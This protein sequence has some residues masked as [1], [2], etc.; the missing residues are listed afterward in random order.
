MKIKMSL[1]YT[2]IFLLAFTSCKSSEAQSRQ[3]LVNESKDKIIEENK[4]IAAT[5]ESA[6]IE[7]NIPAVS[8]SVVRG[9]AISYVDEFGIMKRG[10]E[11]KIDKNSMYE[12][13]SIAKTFTGIITNYLIDEGKLNL[14]E[15]IITYLDNVLTKE[16]KENLKN[17]QLKHL[18]SHTAGIP[19]RLCSIYNK[20]ESNYT[21]GYTEQEFI[22][23]LNKIVLNSEPGEKFSYSSSGYNIAGYICELVSGQSYDELLREYVTGRSIKYGMKNTVISLNE[24]QTNNLVTAYRPENRSKP[25]N[26]KTDWGKAV[27][28][29]G[30]YSTVTD[31][32][33]LA[34]VQM[35]AY[36]DYKTNGIRTP[37]ILTD[38][39]EITGDYGLG[40]IKGEKENYTFYV[41]EGNN[42]G[43]RT[44]YLLFPDY[45]IALILFTSSGG[46][47][48]GPL[49]TEIYHKLI[50]MP[51]S[52]PKKSLAQ[53]FIDIIQNENMETGIQF[54]N[55]HKALGTYYLS[56]AEMNQV[57]YA[58]LKMDRIKDAIEAFKLNVVEFPKSSNAYDSLAEAYLKN[59]NK[60][61]ALLNYEKS[62]ELDPKNENAKNIIMKL[63]L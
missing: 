38:F 56:E 55:K 37:L 11:K 16:A 1:I 4:W 20:Q 46:P 48:M 6:M 2:S 31:L 57:G 42:N 40:L 45:D 52:K 17:V 53:S 51:Y 63:K 12:L 19:H 21:K 14:E 58:L 49:A 27:P 8:I 60:K 22:N 33:K 9:G 10:S 35:R 30:T 39:D 18:M 47:W 34:I 28:A 36:Q 54:F 15:P 5:I 24:K 29:S 62:L 26:V 32:S 23:D 3:K 7:N 44:L 61:Q 59:G 43:F 50:E 13:A 41:N 25:A